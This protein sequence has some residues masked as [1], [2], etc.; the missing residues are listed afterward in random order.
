MS[1]I[2]TRFFCPNRVAAERTAKRMDEVA[3]T[4][5]EVSLTADAPV[6]GSYCGSCRGSFA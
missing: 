5:S 2:F 3:E 4:L 1:N 6:P